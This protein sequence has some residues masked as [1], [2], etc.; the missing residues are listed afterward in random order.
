MVAAVKR[1]ASLSDP[2]GNTWLAGMIIE[3]MEFARA[4]EGFTR[5]K[6]VTKKTSKKRLTVVCSCSIVANCIGSSSG[7][8]WS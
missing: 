6:E 3:A 8:T 5:A 7:L 1:S 2:N 4:G